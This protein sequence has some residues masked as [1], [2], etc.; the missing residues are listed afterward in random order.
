VR[1]SSRSEPVRE[2]EEILFVNGVEH[3]D[4]CALDDL[5]FQSR[6]C[7]R[8]L[9]TIRLWYVRP[10][11]WMRPIRSPMDSSVQTHLTAEFDEARTYLAKRQ[12]INLSRAA[13]VAYK[14]SVRR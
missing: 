12:A 9:S 2:P 6:D 14:F 13:E 8:L 11:R 7:Q 3:H 5:V 1:L 4:A 10:T